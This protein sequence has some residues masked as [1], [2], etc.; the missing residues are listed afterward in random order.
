MYNVPVIGINTWDIDAPL[1]TASSPDEA[2]A[3]AFEK[4]TE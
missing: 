1:I 2:V 4:I 3:L